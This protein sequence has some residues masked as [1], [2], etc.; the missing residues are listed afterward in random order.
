MFWFGVM[1]TVEVFLS[2]FIVWGFIHE[3]RFVEW[4]DKLFDRLKKWAKD[5]VMNKLHKHRLTIVPYVPV[6][7]DIVHELKTGSRYGN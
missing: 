6:N 7:E 3:D 1:I 2:V 4:E 5:V